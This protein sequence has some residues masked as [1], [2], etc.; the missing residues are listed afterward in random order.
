VANQVIPVASRE[1]VTISP[2]THSV[3]IP[4]Y[5]EA[6]TITRAVQET[7]KVLH[8]LGQPFEIIVVDDGSTDTTWN[9]LSDLTA[10]EPNLH[11]IRL[12]KNQGKGAALKTGV[13]KAK[14]LLIG[15]L[16]ADLATHPQE[17][18]KGFALLNKADL[19][20]GSRRVPEATIQKPQTRL[21]SFAGQ[22]VN[23]AVRLSLDLPYRDTQCGC[24]TFR[25]EAARTLF[26]ALTTNG[27][28]FD[29]ELLFHAHTN[30]YNVVEFPVT[31]VNG[32]TSRVRIHHALQILRD[33]RRIK[34]K[35]AS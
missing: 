2:P 29:T 17:L 34:Q 18:I 22:C 5:N 35:R 19:A 23:F 32:P 27:W 11:P 12:P 15:F 4:A 10:T 13:N 14:G 33:L 24:K 1:E 30:A 16:D 25:A 7:S 8:D 9:I 21:R 3:I 6:S 26:T 31:W 28:I 20:I